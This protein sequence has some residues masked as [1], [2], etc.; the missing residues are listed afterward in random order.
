[1]NSTIPLS[2]VQLQCFWNACRKQ[3]AFSKTAFLA[4]DKA[5]EQADGLHGGAVDRVLSPRTGG[6]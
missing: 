1:M 5:I 4:A 2:A 3:V 6:P